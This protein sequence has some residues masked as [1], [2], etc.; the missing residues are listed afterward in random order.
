VLMMQMFLFS[1][2]LLL[3]CPAGQPWLLLQNWR[4]LG[5]DHMWLLFCCNKTGA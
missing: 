4:C 1:A 5:A 3:V 2:G